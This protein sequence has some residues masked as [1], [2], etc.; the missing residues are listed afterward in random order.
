[1]EM[2]ECL[3]YDNRCMGVDKTPCTPIGIILHSSGSNNPNLKRYVQPSKDD[4]FYDY[5]I[6]RIGYNKNNNSHNRKS[7]SKSMHIYVGKDSEGKTIGCH[8]VDYNLS[9]WG[10]GKGKNGSYNYP[11][12]A[13]IQIECLEDDLKDE[14][15]FMSIYNYLI[16]CCASLCTE[17]NLPV[18]S[19]TTHKQAHKMGYASNHKDIDHWFEAYGKTLDD[20][21]R[22]VEL[23]IATSNNYKEFDITINTK[24]GVYNVRGEYCKIK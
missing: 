20:F 18:E 15:Y 14:A 11:P 19:I 9:A 10:C 17:F 6:E 7:S 1:M 4:E 24:D 22:D 5:L 13:H 2:L 12:T 3:F 23:H 16:E 21:I 8:T